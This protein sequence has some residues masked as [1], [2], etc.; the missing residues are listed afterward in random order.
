MAKVQNLVVD[1][2]ILTQVANSFRKSGKATLGVAVLV[3]ALRG[4]GASYLR[5]TCS[6]HAQDG[7]PLVP[8]RRLPVRREVKTRQGK[9]RQKEV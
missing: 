5:R 1:N 8:Q 6:V 4:L 9:A 2:V 7:C 3:V